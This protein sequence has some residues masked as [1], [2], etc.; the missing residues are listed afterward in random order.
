M[1]LF[2]LDS[3]LSL[4]GLRPD[5]CMPPASGNLNSRASAFLRGPCCISRGDGAIIELIRRYAAGEPW[6][7]PE[8]S[9]LLSTC[10]GTATSKGANAQAATGPERDARLFYQE[11]AAILKEIQAEVSAGQP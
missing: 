2:S 8:L 6:N 5:T 3:A 10:L 9:G 1:L 7:D 11:A 4:M